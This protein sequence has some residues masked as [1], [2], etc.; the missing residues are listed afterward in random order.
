MLD[1]DILF[2]DTSSEIMQVPLFFFLTRDVKQQ[3]V[4]ARSKF[5]FSFRV[6][7]DKNDQVIWD[8]VWKWI[9]NSLFFFN[10]GLWG[11][12]HSGHSWPIVPASGD[13]GDDCG[14]VDG[15]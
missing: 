4:T 13:N 8:F 3:M 2:G 14:E 6:E 11:Y 7:S 9:I 5:N 1:P 10:S 15:M 12:W